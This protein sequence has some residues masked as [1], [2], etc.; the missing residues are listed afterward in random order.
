MLQKSLTFLKSKIV[1]PFIKL[2]KTGISPEKLA[3]SVGIGLALTVIPMFGVTTILGIAIAYVLRLNQV[4]IHT[5]GYVVYPLQFI[6]LIPF[7]QMGNWL[8]GLPALDLTLVQFMAMVETDVLGAIGELWWTTMRAVV[9]WLLVTPLIVGTTVM[10]LTSVF[11]GVQEKY[12]AV[13]HHL[14]EA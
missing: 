1:D 11:R 12:R 10:I 6:L 2:L 13:W 4:A 8:F 5:V 9:A 7:F 3:L 14:Q